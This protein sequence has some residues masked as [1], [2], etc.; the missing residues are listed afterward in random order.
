M[1]LD[2]VS[3]D[4]SG[5]PLLAGGLGLPL[6]RGHR[7]DRGVKAARYQPVLFL[8]ISHRTSVRRL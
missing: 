7:P 8:E 2:H 1:T 4:I 5:P 3:H 6:V